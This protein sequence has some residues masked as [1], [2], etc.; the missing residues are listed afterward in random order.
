MAKCAGFVEGHRSPDVNVASITNEVP[1]RWAFSVQN[2]LVGVVIGVVRDF[3]KGRI[4]PLIANSTA[5]GQGCVEA[6]IVI[7]GVDFRFPQLQR[8][9]DI[10]NNI[11]YGFTRFVSV[12]FFD[13]LH[14]N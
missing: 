14:A 13:A 8:A 9:K 3:Q 5:N 1:S 2:G 7:C 4:I 6:P 12:I 11:I 10:F